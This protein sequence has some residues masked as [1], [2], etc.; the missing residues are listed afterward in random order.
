MTTATHLTSTVESPHDPGMDR[1]RFLLTSLAGAL[2]AP[3][4]AEGQPTARMFRIGF[5]PSGAG[6][7]HRRQLEALDEGLRALGYVQGKNIAITALWPKTP[8]ELPELAALLVKQNVE[9]IVAPSSPAVAALKRVTVTIPIVFATAAD[10]VGSGFVASLARPGGNITGLSQL[11]VELSGKRVDLLREAFP[12]PKAVVLSLEADDEAALNTAKATRQETE[13]RGRA[14]GLE[15]RVLRVL[16]AEDLSTALGGLHPQRDGGLI[17]LPSPM[18][19]THASTIAELTLKQK[20]PAVSSFHNFAEG[21]GLMTYGVD[22]DDQLRRAATY[23]DKILKGARPGDI[24]VEQA[25]KFDLVIN[26]KTAKALGLTIPPSLLARAD[27][28][29]E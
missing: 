13:R 20:L 12:F 18:A 22:L 24:P 17:I 3:V 28:V 14:L 2:A 21:G 8:S 23:V 15:L 1:R 19:V 11:N 5:L 25:T 9:L 6:P 29:I 7:A 26:L 10:P 16:K 27:R 4:A